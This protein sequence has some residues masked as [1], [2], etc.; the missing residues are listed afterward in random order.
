MSYPHLYI[1]EMV[2]DV[3]PDSVAV[4]QIELEL[5]KL[6]FDPTMGVY[7]GVEGEDLITGKALP[8]L[9]KTYGNDYAKLVDGAKKRDSFAINGLLYALTYAR[10]ASV[11]ALVVYDKNEL[12]PTVTEL[13]VPHRGTRLQD[14]ARAIIFFSGS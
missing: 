8:H 1:P 12:R 14:A 10:Q 13:W 9:T 3:D 5:K 6:P 4:E 11:P 7:T 2:L